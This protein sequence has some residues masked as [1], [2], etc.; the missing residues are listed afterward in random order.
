MGSMP[1]DLKNFSVKQKQNTKKK[2]KKNFDVVVGF[3]F[4]E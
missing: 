2:K 3:C 1:L 4:L